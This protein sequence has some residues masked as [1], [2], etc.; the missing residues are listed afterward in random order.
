MHFIH[1]HALLLLRLLTVRNNSKCCFLISAGV[2]LVHEEK[3]SEQ[4]PTP[5]HHL[6][7]SRFII[8]GPSQF[9]SGVLCERH[10]ARWQYR[11]NAASGK[12]PSRQPGVLCERHVARWQLRGNT[13]SGEA[14]SR[15]PGGFVRWDPSVASQYVAPNCCDA[16]QIRWRSV[17]RRCGM[18]RSV[19]TQPFFHGKSSKKNSLAQ[20]KTRVWNE[21][22]EYK[23][24]S[25]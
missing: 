22:S 14:L 8:L 17:R 19:A 10:V 11:G 21:R 16:N 1:L 3:G 15:R 25:D 13:A 12:A 9:H 7:I 5:G 18:A 4:A 24:R 23:V 2:H 20:R 6:T